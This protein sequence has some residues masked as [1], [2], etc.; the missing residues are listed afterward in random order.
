MS[1]SMWLP[2]AKVVTARSSG[3]LLGGNR[4]C[5][6]HTTENDPTRTTAIN[7]ANYLNSVNSAG[8]FVVHPISGEIVQMMPANAVTV[9][10]RH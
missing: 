4:F 8:H 3:S 7:L 10:I 1:A 2:G 5:T 9:N 6:W